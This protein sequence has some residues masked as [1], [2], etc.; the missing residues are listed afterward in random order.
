M[1]NFIELLAEIPNF[2]QRGELAIEPLAPLSMVAKQPGKYYTSQS[3]PTAPMLYGMLENAL[4]WHLSDKERVALFKELAKRHKLTGKPEASGSGYQSL[5]QWHVRFGV[6]VTPPLLA[7]DDLW[8]QHLRGKG[9]VGGS[10]NHD[11][12]AMQ[13]VSA[14]NDKS[15]KITFTDSAKA[16]NDPDTLTKFCD[17]EEIHLNVLRPYFPQYYISPTRRGYVEAQGSYLVEV[18]TSPALAEALQ[19]AVATPA[20]PLYLGSNDGWVEAF[21]LPLL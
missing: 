15:R 17:G 13:L 4:G 11:I 9:F 12:L 19:I 10:R 7:Y 2:S 16:S 3:A 14:S 1:I 6:V 8:S 21:W 5:L 18:A 20:A